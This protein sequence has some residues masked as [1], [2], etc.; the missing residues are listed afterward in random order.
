M[1]DAEHVKN[2]DDSCLECQE[3]IK[4]HNRY[5]EARHFYEQAKTEENIEE[6]QRSKT[7]IYSMDLQKVIMLPQMEQFKE[8]VLTKRIDVFNES[9]VPVGKQQIIKPVARLWH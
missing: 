4:H 3:W 2:P 6:L 8:V 7:V 9:F 5:K 1:H